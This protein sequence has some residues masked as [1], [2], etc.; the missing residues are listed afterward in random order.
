MLAAVAELP[1]FGLYRV[2]VTPGIVPEGIALFIGV[3]RRRFRPLCQLLV[4]LVERG[5]R[6]RLGIVGQFG[7]FAR[8]VAVFVCRVRVSLIVGR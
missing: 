1:I 7:Q 5:T 3:A 4:P 8:V 2:I 6:I